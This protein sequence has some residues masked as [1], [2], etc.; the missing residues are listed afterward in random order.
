MNYRLSIMLIL[1]ITI[2]G[3]TKPNFIFQDYNSDQIIH[4]SQVKNFEELS[5]YVV[6]LNAGDTI[7]LKMTLDSK[8]LDIVHED[9]HLKLKQKVYFRIKIPEGINEKYINEISEKDRQNFFQNFI[10]YLSL[11]TKKWAPY[12][13]LKAVSQLFGIKGGSFSFGM[14][15]VRD[16]GLEIFLNAK[17]NSISRQATGRK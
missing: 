14:G 10:I 2:A 13:D 12:T 9:I 7:S 3:C 11:D 5:N 1:L 8:L 6:Y 16:N 15:V 4:F 17:T